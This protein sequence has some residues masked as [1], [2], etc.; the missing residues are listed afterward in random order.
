MVS[1]TLKQ[2]EKN[3]WITRIPDEEDKRLVHLYLTEEGERLAKETMA[4]QKE[5]TCYAAQ[6]LSEEE[7]VKM[8]SQLEKLMAYMRD[9]KE[10]DWL[11]SREQ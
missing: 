6:G 1:K 11:C 5:I 4:I 3:G 2:L 10:K 7:C 9:W 8:E